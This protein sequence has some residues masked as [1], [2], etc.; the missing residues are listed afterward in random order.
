MPNDLE[1][2]LRRAA[3]IRQQKS[4]EQR[5]EA[6]RAAEQENR[7]R[8]RQYTNALSE[9]QVDA[10]QLDYDD[11]DET[12]L[13]IEILEEESRGFDSNRTQPA[14]NSHSAGISHGHSKPA[15]RQTSTASELKAMLARPDGV[16]QAF[17]IREILNRPRF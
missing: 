12:V 11:D 7:S 13:G 10:A 17:L 5:A 8:P 14:D 16:R 6:Q 15:K 4:L 9:R 1:E 3:E 2:F